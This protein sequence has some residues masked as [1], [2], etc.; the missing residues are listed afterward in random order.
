M[1]LDGSADLYDAGVGDIIT[2]KTHCPATVTVTGWAHAIVSDRTSTAC[3][4]AGMR[5]DLC[6]L[7]WR[8]ASGWHGTTTLSDATRIAVVAKAGP[9]DPARQQYEADLEAAPAELAAT[10]GEG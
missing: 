6:R 5:G 3:L 1:N 9:D 2:I 10:A 8:A 7:S 4:W